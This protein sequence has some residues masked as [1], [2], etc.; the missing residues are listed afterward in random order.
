MSSCS[1]NKGAGASHAPAAAAAA[2]PA[3]PAP[4]QAPPAAPQ[5]LSKEELGNKLRGTLEEYF[6]AR[7]KAELTQTV[8]ELLDKTDAAQIFEQ[9]PLVAVG[10]MRGVDW[11]IITVSSCITGVRAAAH[12]A[13]LTLCLV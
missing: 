4:S 8:K 10:K 7:D 1:D 13:H 3:A 12:L 2:E 6:S 9:I 5:K 11:D